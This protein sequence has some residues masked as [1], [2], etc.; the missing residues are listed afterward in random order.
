[1]NA[2]TAE[3][4]VDT[5]APFR[6][7][8]GPSGRYY[9]RIFLRIQ[10]ATL[11][12]RHLSVAA[13]LGSFVWASLRGNWLL[14]WIGFCTDMVVAVNLA[15]VYKYNLAAAQAVIDGKEFLVQRYESWTGAY[16][17]AAVVLFVAGRLALG[18]LADRLYTWRAPATLDGA[19]ARR[20]SS[21][22]HPCHPPMDAD[23]E[24]S[25]RRA[26]GPSRLAGFTRTLRSFPHS[27]RP[28]A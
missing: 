1:M 28:H 16:L 17:L 13:M 10:R 25:G 24:R 9:A 15:L 23:P 27:Q 18:W 20:S 14:F 3:A 5:L 7:F 4:S 6:E 2:N 26:G 22:L 21:S 8:A 12:S 11:P 19:G